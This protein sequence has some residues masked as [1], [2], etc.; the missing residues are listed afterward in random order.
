MGNILT[1]K[2]VTVAYR[3]R[4]YHKDALRSL[5]LEITRGEVFGFLGP[6]G[7]GKTTTI[8]A[9]LNLLYPREGEIKIFGGPNSNYK[10]R[11]RLGYMPEIANYYWYLR[12]RELLLMYAGF[13]GINKKE[14][15]TKINQLFA[16]VGIDKEADVLMKNFSKGMMQKVSLAQALINDPELL[17]LDEPTSGLDPI[18]R[19]NV[20]DIIHD[21]KTQGKT[22]FFS[23][24]ELS[25][26][27][28]ICDRIGILHNGRMLKVENMQNIL[29]RK[30][31][32]MSLERY[33]LSIIKGE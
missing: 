9:I 11:S 23:S 29:Q 33:F 13:F 6:N 28:L 26:A 30:E 27:E 17:I 3:N 32:N 18:A 31:Q 10:L 20:R 1:L 15:N 19:M 14:A 21:L 16:L 7:A 4:D 22:V 5:T 25:E 8:K 2:N 24:H 12:P